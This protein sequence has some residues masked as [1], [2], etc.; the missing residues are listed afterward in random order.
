M[1]QQV[2]AGQP[3]LREMASSYAALSPQLKVIARYVE[4]HHD[5]LGQQ[6]IQDVAA[7]C[8]VQPSAVVRFAKRFGLRGYQELKLAL[9][10]SWAPL[11]EATAPAGKPGA[12]D[13]SPPPTAPAGPAPAADS[14][15]RQVQD[16]L[17]AAAAHLDQLRSALHSSAYEAI[18]R[19]LAGARRIWIVGALQAFPVAAYL[20][21]H[22]GRS[23]A[24]VHWLS[25]LGGPPS[26]LSGAGPEDV[27]L[28]ISLGTGSATVLD[29][30]SRARARGLSLVVL[31]DPRHPVLTQDPSHTLW[32]DHAGPGLITAM[33]AADGLCRAWAWA[34]D[35]RRARTAGP[36][37]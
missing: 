12:D 26:E 20:A 36:P 18:G 25:L 33:A 9:D 4:R 6:R 10:S 28:V 14:C 22:L 24:P 21:D 30:V 19:R 11:A 1:P 23:D 13:A 35:E 31:G 7:R 3:L 34:R 32:L 27:L 16:G 8:Q 37:R 17:D 2:T 29:L 15:A 5:T